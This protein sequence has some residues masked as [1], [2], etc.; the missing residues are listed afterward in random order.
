M[1]NDIP[2][3]DSLFDDFW[4]A[5]MTYAT[6]N[7]AALDIDVLDPQWTDL[8]AAKSDWDT[9]YPA[10][11][12][13]RAL[14]QSQREAKDVSRDTG[15]GQLTALIAVLRANKAQVSQAELE[16]LG[17]SVYD[18]IRTPVPVPTTRPV[19]KID[20]SQR[21]RHTLSWADEATPTSIRKPAGVHGMELYLKVGGTPPVSLA[22][23]TFIVVDPKSPYLW[24]FDPEDYGQEAHWIG[25]WVNT[26][27]QAGP[28][29]ET[30]TAT[31][32]A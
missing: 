4:T 10:H 17:L 24:E 21:H 1:A 13:G 14:A 2:D 12:A 19:V 11:I 20:H 8:V 22:E 31:V 5:F 18:T 16:A 9:K 23:C 32:V 3:S 30:V 25:R 15:E 7:A 26:R 27:G 29:S 28:I 6:A